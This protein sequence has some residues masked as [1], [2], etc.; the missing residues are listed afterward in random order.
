MDVNPVNDNVFHIL[1]CNAR[2]VGDVDIGASAVDCLVTVHDKLLFELD[3]HVSL[4]DDPQRLVLNNSV[5]QSAWPGIDWIVVIGI[6]DNIESAVL[7][8]NGVPAESNG[9]VCKP[10]SIVFPICIAAPTI[11]DRVPRPASQIT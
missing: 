5:A 11:I 4:K 9:A 7:P 10:L 1:Y 2:T 3:D 8:S 6:C